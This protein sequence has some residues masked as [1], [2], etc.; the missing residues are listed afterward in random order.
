[1]LGG[2]QDGNPP[3]RPVRSSDY[4]D[5]SGLAISWWGGCTPQDW[6]SVLATPGCAEV[7][8][9]TCGARQALSMQPTPAQNRRK[10]VGKAEQ[11]LLSQAGGFGEGG[12]GPPPRFQNGG[13]CSAASF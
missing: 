8:V 9:S 5:P 2:A 4:K 6:G 12:G 10:E 3:T 13:Q 1:M 11:F 7:G